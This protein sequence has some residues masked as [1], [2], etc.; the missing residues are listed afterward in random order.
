MNDYN[1]ILEMLTKQMEKDNCCPQKP[2]S[3]S[4]FEDCFFSL[5]SQNFTG[6]AS[7]LGFII[8]SRLNSNQQNSFGNFLQ[9]LGQTMLTISAQDSTLQSDDNNSQV[10]EQL[11]L[12][13]KQIEIIERQLK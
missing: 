11:E 1:R 7:V 6:L 4:N 5:P 10:A 13:K 8:A 3:K 2:S 12:I 9:L